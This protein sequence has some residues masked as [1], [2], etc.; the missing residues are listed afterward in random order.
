MLQNSLQR[1]NMNSQ[2]VFKS[3]ADKLEKQYQNKIQAEQYARWTLETITK[4]KLAQ[5]I[6]NPTII[7]D[8]LQAKINHW[9]VQLIEHEEPIQYLI[10]SVPF[11]DLE[12]FVKHPVLIPRPETEEWVIGLAANIKNLAGSQPLKILDACT[13]SG[14]IALFLASVL[15]N[16]QII[17]ID[18]ADHAIALAEKNK[19]HLKLAN[20]SFVNADITTYQPNERFDLIV[21]NP[22]Y[23]DHD[24]WL[25]LSPSVT[26]W[27]DYHALVADDNGY[28]LIETLINKAPE[29]LKTDSI[30]GKSKIPQ[31]VI[32]IGH[33][34]GKQTLVLAQKNPAFS[35]SKINQDYAGKD[36]IFSGFI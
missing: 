30:F 21:S 19:A 7:T 31:L 17:G 16:A 26:A 13:G 15:P 25:T 5:L 36:R 20:V 24:D 1:Y 3:I 34:Q 9:L 18:N 22:P 10:G 12:I 6:A 28:A 2:E 29:L 27:E 32:E 11:G 4:Q 33:T 35:N 23:I 8:A 14:C